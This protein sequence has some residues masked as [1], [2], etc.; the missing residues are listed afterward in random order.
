MASI[1]SPGLGSN[2][3][4][5]GIVSQ[6]MSVE[7]QPLAALQKKQASYNAQLSAIGSVKGALSNFQ[8]VLKSLSDINKF[9]NTT[10]T[11]S[12]AAV[13]TAATGKGAVAGSYSIEVKQLAQPQKLASGGFTDTSTLLGGGVLT[14]DLGTITGTVGP[15]GKYPSGSF[16]NNENGTTSITIDPAKSSLADIRDA[17][18]TANFGVK[19]TIVNDG[20]EKPYRLVLSSNKTG[21]TNSIQIKTDSGSALA[22]HFTHDISGGAA[23]QAFTETA[24]AQNALFTVDGVSIS[25]TTNT[26]DDVVAGLTFTLN[27][28]NVGSKATINVAQDTAGVQGAVGQFVFAYNQVMGTLRGV[29]AYDPATKRAAALNGD[30]AV[31]SIQ[32]AIRGML[33]TPVAG[34][35][36]AFTALP[37]IGVTIQKDGSMALDNAKLSAA[38]TSNGAQIAGLFAGVGSTSDNGVKYVTA[39]SDTVANSYELN[40]TKMATQASVASDGPSSLNYVDGVDDILTVNVNGL[41][42]N[43]KLKAGT[44]ASADALATDLQSKINGYQGM[45][46]GG[47]KVLVTNNNGVLT[48][49]SNL[50]GSVSSI[51]VGGSAAAKLLGTTPNKIAGQDVEGSLGG[52]AAN[53]S[54]Q[55][56][57]GSAASPS[58]GLQVQVTSGIAS[59]R[60]TVNYSKGY[61]A[62]LDSLVSEFLGT[63]GAVASKVDGINASI[64]TL[65]SKQQTLSDRLDTLEKRYRTQFTA[66][67]VSLSSM[68][69]TSNYLAQQLA[70]LQSSI[71]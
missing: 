20:G 30:P 63:T 2:L 66:L 49:S 18:N 5:N 8:S 62:Q 57:T 4:V 55:T 7:Q 33:N 34:G 46:S 22:E 51:T 61:A 14:F 39:T 10:A 50:F 65:T 42:V 59:A 69:S 15:D 16:K 64:K 48:L 9:Q 67:D 44:Y 19:A 21:V 68:T 54:G 71:S 1:S 31:R 13:V 28:T 40:I 70:A 3:D 58:A 47:H 32:T 41:D 11:S 38:I 35:A 17:I 56:L 25:K 36:S 6:L 52:A 27:K 43:V 23:T 45:S 26:A 12:D 60:G 37:Q 29:S 53:G 24:A